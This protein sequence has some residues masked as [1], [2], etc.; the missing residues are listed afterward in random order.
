MLIGCHMAEWFVCS[1]ID[2]TEKGFKT[3]KVTAPTYD[4]AV[5]VAGPEFSIA[6]EI[7]KNAVRSAQTFVQIVDEPS[8]KKVL[9]ILERTDDLRFMTT[10][11]PDP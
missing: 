11:Q 6:I 10:G 9:R 5:K 7:K 3:V 4:E 8:L 2:L 1:F